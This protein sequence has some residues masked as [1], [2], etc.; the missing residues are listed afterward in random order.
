MSVLVVCTKTLLYYVYLYTHF[1]VASSNSPGPV[2]NR[3]GLVHLFA[4]F[5][6]CSSHHV[7]V[8]FAAGIVL[9]CDVS[10]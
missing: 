10:S 1:C 3:T 5:R 6:H 4:K 9:T 7:L 2:Q 8:D